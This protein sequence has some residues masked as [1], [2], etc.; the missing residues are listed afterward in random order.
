MAAVQ[1][2][3]PGDP[4]RPGYYCEL[5]QFKVASRVHD[6]V[7]QLAGDYFAP[8]NVNSATAAGE[9]AARDLVSALEGRST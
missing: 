3:H 2:G 4:D 1:L 5:V 6:S 9:R 7:I 8:S